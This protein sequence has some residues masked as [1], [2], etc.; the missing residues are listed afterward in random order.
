M[1]YPAIVQQ[2]SS[3]PREQPG[4]LVDIEHI[5]AAGST[6]GTALANFYARAIQLPLQPLAAAAGAKA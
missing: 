4:H 6:N 3:Q 5:S 2:L 1:R